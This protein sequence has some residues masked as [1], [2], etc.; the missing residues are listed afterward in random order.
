MIGTLGLNDAKWIEMGSWLRTAAL[1]ASLKIE[2]LPE[3]I[4]SYEEG[5]LID[6]ISAEAYA[7]A[8]L[9]VGSEALSPAAAKVRQMALSWLDG[10]GCGQEYMI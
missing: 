6:A 9:I 2:A 5:K 3:D 10:K 8:T 7:L 1:D 4:E